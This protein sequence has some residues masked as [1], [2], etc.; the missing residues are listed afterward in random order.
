MKRTTTS[1]IRVTFLKI[2]EVGLAFLNNGVEVA[3]KTSSNT[4]GVK[5][6]IRNLVPL[7]IKK[8]T[9]SSVALPSSYQTGLGCSK[10]G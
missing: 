6:A 3:I 8:I 4:N 2:L 10:A 9:I 1:A 7:L 5:R